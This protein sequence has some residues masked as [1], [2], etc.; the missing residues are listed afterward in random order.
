MENRRYKFPSAGCT[1]YLEKKEKKNQVREILLF[2]EQKKMMKLGR[3][4]IFEA[5]CHAVFFTVFKGTSIETYT[6]G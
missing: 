6:K 2:S 3:D 4:T 1:K 5:F